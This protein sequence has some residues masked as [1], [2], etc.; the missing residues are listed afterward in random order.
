[1]IP[2]DKFLKLII[3][4]DQDLSESGMSIHA[5]PFEAFY[6]VLNEVSP[7]SKVIPSDFGGPENP[8]QELNKLV[9]SWYEK[10]YGDRVKYH[11]G[12]GNYVIEIAGELWEVVYPACFGTINF[13]I[14]ADLAKT[15]RFATI[16]GERE[17][18]EVNILWHV[19]NLTNNIA[20]NL[21]IDEKRRIYDDYMFGLNAVQSLRDL[22]HELLMKQAKHDYDT[23]IDYLFKKLPDYNNSK[24]SSLQFAEKTMKSKLGQLDVEFGKEIIT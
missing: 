18:P 10:R 1:M 23:A 14:D 20:S 17:I 13:T 22:N 9:N 4:I 12:P 19:K 2:Q 8:R 11:L 16:E 3:D 6:R 21:S 15:E 24:W 7:G 5:R